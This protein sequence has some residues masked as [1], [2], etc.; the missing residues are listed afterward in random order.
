MRFVL[1]PVSDKNY[2][3]VILGQ[4]SGVHATQVDPG[5]QGGMSKEPKRLCSTDSQTWIPAFAGMTHGD[6]SNAVQRTFTA[7]H[8]SMP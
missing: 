4:L 8:S 1:R 3:I 6:N 5:I 2:P 7:R